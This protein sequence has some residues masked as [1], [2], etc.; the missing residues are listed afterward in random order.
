MTVSKKKRSPKFKKQSLKIPDIC[1]FR[2]NSSYA[3][4][5]TLLYR[6]RKSGIGRDK[7]LAQLQS[8]SDKKPRVLLYDISVV[9]SA[10]ETGEAHRSINRAADTFYVDCRD[11]RH[12]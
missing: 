5:W 4:V 8:Y 2:P 1:P 11:D 3:Q 12:I 6:S 10:T 7:L 9:T